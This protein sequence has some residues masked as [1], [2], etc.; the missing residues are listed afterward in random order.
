MTN[1]ALHA[2][3]RLREVARTRA[4]LRALRPPPPTRGDVVAGVSVALVLIPQALA[5]ADLAGVPPV[6]GLYAAAAAPIAAALAGSSPYLQTGPV[7]LTSLLTFGALAPLAQAGTDRFASY[8][9]LLALLVGVARLALGLLRWG[10]VAYLMSL[11]VVTGFTAAAAILIVASQVPGMVGADSA[12]LNPVVAAGEA[13][14][15]PDAWSPAAILIGLVTIGIVV[16]GRRISA[17]FPWMLLATIAGLLL[18]SAGV[19]QVAGIGDIP[20]GLPA[21]SLYLPWHAAPELALPALVIA[22]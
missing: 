18:S 7:A 1:R 5:Y 13:V 2:V 22:V 11:P 8:A 14:A 6:H 12:A 10:A 15:R 17:V 9:A 3:T 20:A 21:I 16:L 19:V 4:R